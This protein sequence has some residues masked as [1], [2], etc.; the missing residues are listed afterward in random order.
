MSEIQCSEIEVLLVDFVDGQLDSAEAAMVEWHIAQC[1]ECGETARLLEKSL[2]CARN[3]WEENL[4]AMDDTMGKVAGRGRKIWFGM[5]A[6]IAA[7]A[8]VVC[9]VYFNGGS[10]EV[11]EERVPLAQLM[12]Q[13]DYEIEQAGSAAR[14]LAS[15]EKLA[16]TESLRETAK[17]QYRLIAEVYSGTTAADRARELIE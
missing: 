7:A 9:G 13:F 6:G 17:K 4:A 3:V 15:A 5:A 11:Q 12:A 1:S 14:L 8:I 16:E 2:D 10:G